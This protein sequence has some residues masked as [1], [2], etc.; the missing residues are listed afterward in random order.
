MSSIQRKTWTQ[1]SLLTVAR[2]NILEPP[3]PI[4]KLPGKV[5]N[6]GSDQAMIRQGKRHAVS[7]AHKTNS[8][9]QGKVDLSPNFHGPSY[10]AMPRCQYSPLPTYLT[11]WFQ[12][13]KSKSSQPHIIIYTAAASAA[14][15][16][17]RT[18]MQIDR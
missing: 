3:S 13:P 8:C 1:M 10:V 17:M 7:V 15:Y 6:R 12:S 16:N 18:H 5:R 4:A 14:A 11:R 2:Q 9:P